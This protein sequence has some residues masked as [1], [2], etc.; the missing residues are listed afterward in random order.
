MQ[1]TKAGIIKQNNDANG[2]IYEVQILMY[3]F[4]KIKS[5]LSDMP[6]VTRK[7]SVQLIDSLLDELRFLD[8]SSSVD[9]SDLDNN[10]RFK[11]TSL[12]SEAN[13]LIQIQA[14]DL[15]AFEVSV[16]EIKQ[17]IQDRN[18]QIKLLNS[19]I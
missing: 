14:D 18:R 16:N 5:K 8:F 19:G 4:E 17:L 6:E 9:V 7:K 3:D 15:S 10:I 1:L 13:N 12:S 11:A 2:E